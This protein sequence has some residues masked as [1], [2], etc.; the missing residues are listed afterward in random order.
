MS[1]RA[2]QVL[3]ALLALI[4]VATGVLGL[5]GVRDPLYA[6]L[7]LP[8]APLLDTNLRFY[9]GVWLGLGLALWWV[10]PAIERRETV[11]RAAWGG[12]FLGGIGRTLSLAFIGWP[13]LPF[14]AVIALELVGAPVFVW[15]QARV[16]QH[17]RDA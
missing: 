16:A 8:D 2:L 1:R 15:W 12:I 4:P 17:A 11:F 9:S 7:G 10:V 13:P 6:G 5:L 3:T 14:V